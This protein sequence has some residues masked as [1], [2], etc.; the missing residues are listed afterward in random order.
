MHF[1]SHSRKVPLSALMFIPLL[2]MVLVL[3]AGCAPEPKIRK[4]DLTRQSGIYVVGYTDNFKLRR[5]FENQLADKLRQQQFTVFVSSDEIP[6]ITDSTPEMVIDLAI[7][8]GA[9]AV[10]TVT[11]INSDKPRPDTPQMA[12]QYRMLQDFYHESKNKVNNYNPDKEAFFEIHAFVL[13]SNQ[14]TTIWSGTTWT[15][16]ADGKGGG[17]DSVTETLTQVLVQIRDKIRRGE[18]NL[19]Y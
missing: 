18:V 7:S 10:L 14:P 19:L 17:I 13:D 5:T 4:V 12:S 1:F 8:H 11:P 6:D 3:V 9:V 2:T 16:E 15:F